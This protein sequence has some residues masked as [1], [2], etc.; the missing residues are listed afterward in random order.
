MIKQANIDFAI[1]E[2]SNFDDPMGEAS[3]AGAIFGTTGG[4]MEAAIRTAV[5]TLE[6]R[7]IGQ[8]E[9][10][11]VRGEKKIKE[12]TLNVAGKEVK[13]AVAS[14]LANAR[15]IME[16]IKKG[17]S[18]YHFV[19]IM[20]CPGGCVMGGGQPIKS[21][22]VT[23]SVDV[24]KLRANALYEI[25]EKSTIRKSHENPVMKQLYAEYLEKPG[26]HLAHKYLHTTY[27]PKEKYNI[28]D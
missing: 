11:E 22:K 28:N 26:S 8:I 16:Q 7:S 24:R 14:G 3:G 13:I 15:K 1:L 21:S 2:D 4:V 19:E 20:A 17:E 25:D 27:T 9:Y 18:P 12:A 23:S 6:N 5:D 10:K